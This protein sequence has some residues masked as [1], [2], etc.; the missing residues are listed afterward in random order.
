[1]WSTKDRARYFAQQGRLIEGINKLFPP[2]SRVKVK[3]YF[4][5]LSLYLLTFT[6]SCARRGPAGT[7]MIDV[8]SPSGA[9]VAVYGDTLLP[10]PD[11]WK[12]AAPEME[13]E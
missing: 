12:G 4:P 7:A 3:H 9:I 2:G 5:D 6:K 10:A 11:S 1:M 8:L 13:D